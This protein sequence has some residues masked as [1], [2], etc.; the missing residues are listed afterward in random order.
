MIDGL[1]SFFP[2]LLVMQINFGG[3]VS[4]STVDWPG[5]AASV[6][7]FRGCDLRC[8]Y[9]HNKSILSGEDLRD[10]DEVFEFILQSQILTSGVIFTGGECTEQPDALI[11]L[12]NRCKENEIPAGIHTNGAH[13]EVIRYIA[14]LLTFV[15]LD[16]KTCLVPDAYHVVTGYSHVAEAAQ[17]SLDLCANL[18]HSGKLP[19]FRIAHTEISDESLKWAEWYAREKHVPIVIQKR[20]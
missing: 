3:F 19:E 8:W 17:A 5:R 13:P 7:F 11:Y 2:K 18:Y 6:V 16:I 10:C 9:C 12:L 15:S 20:R 14:P 1:L 4:A